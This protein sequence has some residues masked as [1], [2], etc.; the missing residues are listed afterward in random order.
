MRVADYLVVT[1]PENWQTTAALGWRLL[2]LK[3]TRRNMATRLQPGDH[4]VC[5]ATGIKRFI[6]VVRIAG[7][8]FEEWTQIWS[9]KRDSELYPY[10][11]PIE[12]LVVVGPADGP[13]AEALAPE[14]E[15]PRKWGAHL[16]LAFQGN[17]KPIPAADTDRIAQA[18]LAAR[19]T[20][21][22]P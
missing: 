12:P 22:P 5:Y 3:S 10:R 14:L 6:A 8:C 16:S 19:A 2:G 1:S 7:P 15:F 9:A 11:Y 20:A 4:A 18:L 17:I 21:A 13:D